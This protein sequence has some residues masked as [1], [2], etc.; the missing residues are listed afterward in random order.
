MSRLQFATI[1]PVICT[2]LFS[3]NIAAAPAVVIEDENSIKS[4]VESNIKP[5]SQRSTYEIVDFSD[6]VEFRSKRRV[7]VG[8]MVGG[9]SG[10]YGIGT[11]LNLNTRNSVNT[12]FGG[13]PR[14]ST[15]SMNWKY[16]FSEG[17]I[18]PFAGAGI[19]YWYNSSKRN[20]PI[21]NT[22]PG[23]LTSRFLSENQRASGQFGLSLAAASFGVQYFQL[24][25]PAV[26]ASLFAQV[27]ILAPTED[28]F[29]P[30]ATGSLGGL[31]FF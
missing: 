5:L 15:F 30:L 14:Y 22:T 4:T 17:K 26:G 10:L 20:D 24:E 25:G 21:Q 16:L 19:S 29:K 11:E 6:S 8:A 3:L 18:T 13:G 7:G 31:F 27:D 28:L 12:I 2:M 1:V 9:T 23:F